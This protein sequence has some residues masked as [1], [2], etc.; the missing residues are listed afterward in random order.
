MVNILVVDDD[1]EVRKCLSEILEEAGYSVKCVEN[2]KDAIIA[3]H[4][5]FF[6]VALID[7]QLP[8]MEGIELLG[9]LRKTEP[10]LI[11]IMITGHASLNSSIDATNKGADGYVL[12]PF[13]PEKLLAFI[14]MH[15]KKQK[16]KVVF[17]EKKVAE[18]IETRNYWMSDVRVRNRK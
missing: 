6:N 1:A 13:N 12:K 2:G 17:D 3:S 16:E 8:D 9:K 10:E 15:L 18:Y 7:I 5:E 11:K 4:E 14:E